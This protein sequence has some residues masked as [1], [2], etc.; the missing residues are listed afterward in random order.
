MSTGDPHGSDFPFLKCSICSLRIMAA[1]DE[2]N[3]SAVA[4]GD[5]EG[6]Q[7][8][9]Q[10]V[11]EVPTQ[12]LQQQV[13]AA[14][15]S[16]ARSSK[17]MATPELIPISEEDAATVN[18]LPSLLAWC[19]LSMVNWDKVRG[20]LGEPELDDMPT[21]GN[22]PDA[23]WVE[24]TAGLKAF[25]SIPRTRLGLLI[26]IAR[27]KVGKEPRDYRHIPTA[28]PAAAASGDNTATV[29]AAA[30]AGAA[31]AAVM[32]PAK[33]EIRTNL[34]FDQGLKLSCPQLGTASIDEMRAR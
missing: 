18:D 9:T 25:G 22:I 13:A 16:T 14:T 4:A 29:A 27:L 23:D 15:A 17:G 12:P 1:I 5:L 20:A 7:V 28:L 34:V 8:A 31:A 11:D 26:A 33:N 24:A 21:I 2:T 32:A 30:A 3:P 6:E 19:R 10:A